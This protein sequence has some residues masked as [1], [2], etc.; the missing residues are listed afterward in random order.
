MARKEKGT[1]K[2]TAKLNAS[3]IKRIAYEVNAYNE[4]KQRAHFLRKT[5]KTKTPAYKNTLESLRK[6]MVLLSEVRGKLNARIVKT[7]AKQAAAPT[8]EDLVKQVRDHATANYE[9]DGWDIVVE[10]FEDAE[11]VEEIKECGSMNLRTVL[12]HFKKIC[13]LHNEIRAGHKA[14][15]DAGR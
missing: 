9:K 11:I 7:A 6:T 13:K 1:T 10:A 15:A 8:M 12:R 5:G 14:E 2:M 4:K 3:S